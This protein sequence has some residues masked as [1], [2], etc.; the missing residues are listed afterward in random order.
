MA[1]TTIYEMSRK[2][3]KDMNVNELKRY[4][5]EASGKVVKDRSSRYKS[6]KSSA[7]YIIES[8]GVRYVKNKKTGKYTAKMKL[9]FSGMRK[10]D[11][12][13]RA[14]L[15]QGHF[16]IDVYSR[17]AKEYIDKITEEAMDALYKNTGI[18]I[19]SKEKMAEFK[20]LMSQIK[21]IVEKFGSDNI[22]KLYDELDKSEGSRS[23]ITLGMAIREVYENLPEGA[24]QRDAMD[25]L[26]TYLELMYGEV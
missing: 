22:A 16:K 19:E 6:V 5:R 26:T 14:R 17:N 2:N 1:K 8:I 13:Q 25:S 3:L 4:I 7:E 10:T 12:L 11:L 24:T 20:L 18:R 15:L 9:G 21:D 23:L